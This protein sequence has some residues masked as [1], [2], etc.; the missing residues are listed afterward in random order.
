MVQ[1]M[2]RISEDDNAPLDAITI[3]CS[4]QMSVLAMGVDLLLGFLINITI[5][6]IVFWHV[7]EETIRCKGSLMRLC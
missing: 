2:V 7:I 5:I 6:V 3:E 1:M 4:Q